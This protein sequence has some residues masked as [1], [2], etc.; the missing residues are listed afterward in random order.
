ME[1]TKECARYH[2]W[3]A[4]LGEMYRNKSTPSLSNNF[5]I[6]SFIARITSWQG[7]LVILTIL[8]KNVGNLFIV[9]S[10]KKPSEGV[11]RGIPETTKLI[12]YL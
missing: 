8:G 4:V 1:E 9:E 5:A 6:Q 7:Q 3:M 11:C 12:V 2:D 10:T